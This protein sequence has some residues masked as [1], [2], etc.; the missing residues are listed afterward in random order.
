M[1][2]LVVQLPTRNLLFQKILHIVMCVTHA[3]YWFASKQ[4]GYFVVSTV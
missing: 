1:V 2:D 3:K 4:I